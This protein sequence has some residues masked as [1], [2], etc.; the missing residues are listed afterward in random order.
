MLRRQLSPEECLILQGFRSDYWLFGNKTERYAQIGNAV[1]PPVA[2][3][4]GL[5][6]LEAAR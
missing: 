3:A 1:A 6:I 5:A 2:R 4:I